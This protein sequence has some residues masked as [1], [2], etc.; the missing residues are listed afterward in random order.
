MEVANRINCVSDFADA[1]RWG[2][3]SEELDAIRGELATAMNGR[4][5]SD[6]VTLMTLGAWLREIEV[7]SGH[8]AENY[9]PEG[10]K[11]LGQ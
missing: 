11:A 1:R 6:L 5:D 8:V 3:L 10:A 2:A 7:A 9:T 4:H